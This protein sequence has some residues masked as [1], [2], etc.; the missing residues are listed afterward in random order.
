MLTWWHLRCNGIL[1]RVV[2]RVMCDLAIAHLTH[3]FLGKAVS[4]PSGMPSP[5]STGPVQ[6]SDSLPTC[7][8]PAVCASQT[9]VDCRYLICWYLIQE[10]GDDIG[11]YPADGGT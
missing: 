3:I 9:C 5:Q 7:R 2:L 4:S 11:P 10:A 1:R 8:R 6:Y